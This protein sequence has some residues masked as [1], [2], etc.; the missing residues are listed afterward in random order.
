MWF[1]DSNNIMIRNVKNVKFS[2]FRTENN[3]TLYGIDLDN[4]TT[5]NNFWI[6]AA[7]SLK[8]LRLTLI[9]LIELLGNENN[10]K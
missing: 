2:H 7:N 6:I 9:E 5:D 10:K 3:S 4:T 8:E 1:L